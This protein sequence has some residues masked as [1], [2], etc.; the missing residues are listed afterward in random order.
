MALGSFHKVGE[1]VTGCA[2]TKAFISDSF[3]GLM[4]VPQSKGVSNNAEDEVTS[5][6]AAANTVVPDLGSPKIQ[7]PFAFLGNQPRVTASNAFKT[8]AC[9]GFQSNGMG[10][11][12]HGP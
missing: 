1:N 5:D 10:Q 11:R 12:Y 9:L 6:K 2:A 8:G 3:R 7:C 4:A